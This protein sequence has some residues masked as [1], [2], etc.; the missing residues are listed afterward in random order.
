MAY[1]VDDQQSIIDGLNTLLSGPAGLGQDFQG[2]AAYSD[3]WLTGNFREPFTVVTY[4]IPCISANNS[5]LITTTSS[6]TGIVANLTANGVGIAANTVVTSTNGGTIFLSANTTSVVD[7]YITFAPNVTPQLYVA[8]INLSTAEQTGPTSFKFTFANAQPAP[9]FTPGMNI[10]TAGTSDSFYNDTWAPV[11]VS[12]CTTTYVVAKT[13]N[14]YSNIASATGG[15]VTYYNTSTYPA[16][17]PLSTDC[18]S[19]VN[20]TGGSDR[21]FVSAQLTNEISYTATTSTDLWYTVAINRYTGFPNNNPVNPGFLFA[22][23]HR[24]SLK[25][26]KYTGLNG[27]GTLD[28]VDTIFS[29]F[30]DSNLTP[31][32]YWYIMDVSFQRQNGGDLEVTECKFTLRSM[33]TQVVKQ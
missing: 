24:V 27:T 17:F 21:V 6:T 23:P 13:R 25:T 26:Y 33:S 2:F 9:P 31:G 7:D 22:T 20:V 16:V 10:T 29:N 32:Y 1:P 15:T 8:P 11:G 5:N 18:N 28:V 12:E 3:A 19:K 14:S 30:E 4:N